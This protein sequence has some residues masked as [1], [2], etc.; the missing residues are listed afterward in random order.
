MEHEGQRHLL[1]FCP[2][3]SANF[4]FLS[5][6][7]LSAFPSVGNQLMKTTLIALL[8]FGL[9][10]GAMASSAPVEPPL[11]WRVGPTAWSFR[12][13]TMYE[14]IEKTTALGMHYLEAFE[15]QRVSKEGDAKLNAAAPDAVI[16]GLR[17]KLDAAKI[18]LTS[19]YIH[20]IPGDEAACRKT[21]DFAR[22]LGVEF[23]VS[24]PTPEALPLIEKFCEEYRINLALHNHPEGKSRYWHPR[25]VLKACEGRGPR[26]GACGD[27]GHWLRSGLKPAEMVQLLGPRLLALHVKDLD[28]AKHDTPWGTGKG[29]MPGLFQTLHRLKLKPALFGIEYE[30][31][32][33]NNSPD[34]AQCG[35]FFEQQVRSLTQAHE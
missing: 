4:F 31:K 16:A 1:F 8:G 9:M 14:A 10:A 33:E 23:I 11:G 20:T 26:I 28:E 13:F 34:I 32:W 12:L 5:L 2:Y 35:K 21:F 19:I 7:F 30:S 27:T 18:K 25:E 29:D 15:G 24:E 6:I 22:K 3:L 17:A